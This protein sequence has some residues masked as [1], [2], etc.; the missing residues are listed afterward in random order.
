MLVKYRKLKVRSHAY[1][2]YVADS[3]PQFAIVPEFIQTRLRPYR[4]VV[5]AVK[6]VGGKSRSSRA[7]SY[8]ADGLTLDLNLKLGMGNNG[9]DF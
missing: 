2:N 7:M 1:T 4:I 8:A 5:A 3:Q 9:S 6:T